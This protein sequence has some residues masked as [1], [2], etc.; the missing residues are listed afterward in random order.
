VR[1]QIPLAKTLISPRFGMVADRFGVMW[2]I[3]VPGQ[4]A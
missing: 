4:A 1:G 3:H 2:L